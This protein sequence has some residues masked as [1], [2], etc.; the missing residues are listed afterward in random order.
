M[1]KGFVYIQSSIFFHPLLFFYH[2]FLVYYII[3]GC[4][5]TNT[6]RVTT[7]MIYCVCFFQQFFFLFIFLTRYEAIRAQITCNFFLFI[8]NIFFINFFSLSL[9]LNCFIIVFS[10][11]VDCFF[12]VVFQSD[13]LQIFFKLFFVY[14][15]VCVFFAEPLYE[16]YFS[17]VFKSLSLLLL[18]I[19]HSHSFVSLSLF[20]TVAQFYTHAIVLSLYRTLSIIKHTFTHSY[21]RFRNTGNEKS[22]IFCVYVFFFLACFLAFLCI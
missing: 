19:V 9:S 7:I 18:K 5:F 14:V 6:V 21:S 20:L 4:Y 16:F 10:L 15:F 13:F 8:Y 1:H 3:C 2:Y 17:F 22:I 11:L 12:F